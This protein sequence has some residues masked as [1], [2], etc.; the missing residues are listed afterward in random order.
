VRIGVLVNPI[1]GMGGPLALKGTDGEQILRRV[2]ASGR[3]RTSPERF[4]RAANRLARSPLQLEALCASGEMGEE[5]LREAGITHRVVYQ[6]PESTTREDTLACVRLFVDEGVDLIVFAGGDGTAR[7][8]VEVVGTKVP[9]VGVPSGVKMHSGVFANSPEEAADLV[10]SFARAGSTRE[11][12][13]MD[14]DEEAFR[15]DIVSTRLYAVAA[16]PDDSDHLQPSK[17]SFGSGSARDEV[18]EIGQYMADIMEPGVLYILGPG[19][20]TASIA[21]ALA[22]GKTLL[23]VDAYRDGRRVGQDMDERALLSA[24]GGGDTARIVVTP[25]GAQGFVFGR[26]NQ[27]LSPDVI[28][29]VGRENLIIIAT[30]TKLRHTP[31]LRVDTGDAALDADLSG[32]VRVVTGYRRKRLVSI[33]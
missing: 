32:K 31:D 25:I 8:I 12:E 17:Q 7:D 16:V 23:G 26:G 3:E 18:E 20:T 15:K 1:A 9:M 5:E 24:L 2:Q 27:Q 13:V 11:A 29:R 28:R 22:Q 21:E 33:S 30:P 6:A 14:V 19:S 4:L 10:A